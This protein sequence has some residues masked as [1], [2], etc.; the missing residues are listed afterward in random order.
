METVFS[1]RECGQVKAFLTSKVDLLRPPYGRS[2]Q[3]FARRSVIVGTTNQDDFLNDA[4]GSRRFWVVRVNRPIDL[5]KVKEIR[6]RLWAAAVDAYLAGEQWWLTLEEQAVSN[7]RNQEFSF[8]HPWL[9]TISDY[10]GSR[11]GVTSNEVLDQ[12]KPEVGQQTK[13]DSMAVA[14]CLKHL[15]WK[16]AGRSKVGHKLSRKWINPNYYQPTPP[17]DDPT[18]D[19]PYQPRPTSSPG[20]WSHS[21]DATASNSECH[22]SVMSAEHGLAADTQQPESIGFSWQVQS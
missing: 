8:T 4:T 7:E 18:S 14:D 17:Q 15:G 16:Q 5:E 9:A 10:V 12:I 2:T 3:R 20:G 22:S 6:D 21:N 19:Q 13:A 1:K 11:P